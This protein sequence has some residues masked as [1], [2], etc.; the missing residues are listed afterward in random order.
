M[1]T[2]CDCYVAPVPWYR[3]SNFEFLDSMQYTSLIEYY[4]CMPEPRV[5]L[6]AVQSRCVSVVEKAIDHTNLDVVSTV[7]LVP[8][9]T[10]VELLILGAG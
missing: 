7:T 10:R 2:S 6:T 3:S 4:L 5:W 8:A 9:A 1:K